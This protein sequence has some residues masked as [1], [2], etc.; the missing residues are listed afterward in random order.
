MSLK[1]SQKVDQKRKLVNKV[2]KKC[3]HSHVNMKIQIKST[4][5]NSMPCSS[6]K[7]E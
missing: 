4:I 5:D 3:S 6:I 1:Y 7:E 2:I